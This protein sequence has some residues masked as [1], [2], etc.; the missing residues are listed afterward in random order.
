MITLAPKSFAA[1]N[2]RGI[3]HAKKRAYDLAIADFNKAI[4]IA[5][6]LC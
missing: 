3:I 6:S 4:G 5:S 2:N 1:Y